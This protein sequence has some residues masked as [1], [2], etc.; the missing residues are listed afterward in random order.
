MTFYTFVLGVAGMLMFGYH[1]FDFKVQSTKWV[2]MFT[3]NKELTRRG[4]I[5]L[6]IHKLGVY[7]DLI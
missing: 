1:S 7:C 6:F 3:G 4:I 5:H 2:G